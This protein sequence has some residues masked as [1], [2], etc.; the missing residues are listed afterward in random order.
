M[1][2]LYVNMVSMITC[3]CVLYVYEIL[4]YMEE[5]KFDLYV[6][7]VRMITCIC[8]LYVYVILSY[9]EEIKKYLECKMRTLGNTYKP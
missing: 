2:D 1:F 4:S 7:M 3:I 6:N 8:V 9:M 5:I